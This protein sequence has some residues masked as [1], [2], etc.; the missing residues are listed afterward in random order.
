MGIV[1]AAVL[2]LMVGVFLTALIVSGKQADTWLE[3]MDK[4]G[5]AE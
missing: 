4:N 3:D 5:G 2:G 1:I